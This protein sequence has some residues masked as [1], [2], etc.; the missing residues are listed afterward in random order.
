[1]IV[2]GKIE[3]VVPLRMTVSV[4]R[5]DR[6]RVGR[7]RNV[8]VAGATLSVTVVNVFTV[9][10]GPQSVRAVSSF[11]SLDLAEFVAMIGTGRVD[12]GT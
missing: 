6:R 3:V 8:H 12:R 5:F 2:D 7:K 11:K 10:A 1:M 4:D 9:W